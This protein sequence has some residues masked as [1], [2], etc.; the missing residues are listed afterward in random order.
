MGM[1]CSDGLNME[2]QAKP[3][4][5]F[6]PVSSPNNRDKYL[7]SQNIVQVQS[8]NDFSSHKPPSYR[9]KTWAKGWRRYDVEPVKRRSLNSPSM[10]WQI[11]IRDMD[12]TRYILDHVRE[13]S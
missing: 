13:I 8:A 7:R 5:N 11:R 12:N 1:T 10:T 3:R 9:S 6:I 4:V 2:N